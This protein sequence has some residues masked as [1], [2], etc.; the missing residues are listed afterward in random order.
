MR[1]ISSFFCLLFLFFYGAAGQTEFSQDR[2]LNILHHLSVEI[3]PRPMGSPAEQQAL[4]FAVQQFLL[5][6]CDTAYV[7]AMPTTGAMN[8]SSGIAVGMKRGSSPRMIV[9]GG[10]IDSEG[11][12]VPGA[13]DDGS[14]A[15]SVM[16]LAHV[17]GRTRTTSTLLFCCFGG[18][19]R[20]LR[21]SEYFVAH[22]RDIDSI[23]MMFQIDMANG[24]PN[25]DI[26]PDTHGQNAP[27]WLVRASVEA[28][29]A[30]GY[31]SP[32]YPT[33]YF[34]LNYAFNA[35]AGSDH[36]SFLH[37]GIPAI[38]FSSDVNRPIHTPRDNFENFLPN[39]LQRTGSVV[40][41]LVRR[42]DGNIPTR[43]TERYWLFLVGSIPIFVPFWGIW[44]ITL[45]GFCTAIVAFVWI[46]RKRLPPSDPTRARWT[47]V[48]ILLCTIIIVCCGWFSGDLISLLRGLRH[49]WISAVDE[50]IVYGLAGAAIG[51][52]IASRMSESL[53]V[54]SCPYVHFKRAAI[55]LLIIIVLLGFVNLKLLIEPS[56]ALFLLSLAMLVPNRIIRGLFLA[57]SPWWLFRLIFSE[58]RAFIFRTFGTQLPDNF[59]TWLFFNIGII[60]LLTLF[61]LPFMFGTLAVLHDSGTYDWFTRK[62]R[63]LQFLVV[64]GVL[65]LVATGYLVTIPTY[66][67]LWYRDLRIEE[68]YDAEAGKTA[69]AIQS[70]E[71]LTGLQLHYDQTDTTFT[72]HTT[73]GIVQGQFALESSWVTVHDSDHAIRNGNTTH[74]DLEL[75]LRMRERPFR[76]SVSFFGGRSPLHDFSTPRAY[77]IDKSLATLQ[78]YSFPDTELTIPVSFDVVGKDS[79]RESVGVEFDTLLSPVRWKLDRAYAI[80]RTVFSTS[81][82]IRGE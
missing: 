55:V 27:A 40:E 9:I 56:V 24:T 66:N 5:A 35:G 68:R 37:A 11:P 74:H 50:F 47:T 1:T 46:R 60:F 32:R 51:L 59:G 52:W 22:F 2:A 42:F 48:K 18:E 31:P 36:E 57:L 63:S 12:E 29:S 49:P 81:K 10:H 75:H 79:I 39:G 77:E 19:E 72:S 58:W 71:Y 28:F 78:W 30:L 41:H 33:H 43:Q 15:A 8:T 62:F 4:A 7:M 73:S 64:V 26:D 3:G 69:L 6:G 34:S 65:F 21:G 70:S 80:P 38:D 14:G 20:G 45:V 23:D 67:S 82:W 16:E 54:S 13:D 44:L 76:V 53:H 17:F 25:I 61:L